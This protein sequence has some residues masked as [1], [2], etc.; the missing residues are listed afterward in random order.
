M[1]EALERATARSS[2]SEHMSE[3]QESG[4]DSKGET[5]GFDVALIDR[6]SSLAGLAI[7]AEWSYGDVGH[8]AASGIE[9]GRRWP[10]RAD[11][12]PFEAT[13]RSLL[14]LDE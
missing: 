8:D 6:C 14:N 11:G 9:R 5:P 10:S 12:S 4:E 7:A 3:G 2:F 13:S 1:H